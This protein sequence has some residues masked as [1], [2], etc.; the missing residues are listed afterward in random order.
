M[1]NYYPERIRAIQTAINDLNDGYDL[2]SSIKRVLKR[3]EFILEQTW[4][5]VRMHLGF[6]EGF[7]QNSDFSTA[8]S[9]V[10]L[11]IEDDGIV[12]FDTI[13]ETEQLI[14]ESINNDAFE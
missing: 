7:L 12:V 1:R 8:D 3:E 5:D 11:N 2:T 9:D 6:L 13:N 10:T 14:L 4:D